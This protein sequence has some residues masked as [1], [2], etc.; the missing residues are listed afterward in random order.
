[1]SGTMHRLRFVALSAVGWAVACGG[2][3]RVPLA[4]GTEESGSIDSERAGEITTAASSDGPASA[5]PVVAISAQSVEVE[6]E[7]EAVTERQEVFGF[8]TGIRLLDS[9]NDIT[10]V[11]PVLAALAVS[12]ATELRRWQPKADFRVTGGKLALTT[13][14]RA[15]CADGRCLNTQA[16]LDLQSDE[17]GQALIRPDVQVNPVLL[18][19]ALSLAYV[20]QATCFTTLGVPF[21][22][23]SVPDHEFTLA[24][25]APGECDTNYWFSTTTEAGEP[26]A[27]ELM[28][29]LEKSLIWV[30]TETN[31]YIQF[32]TDGNLVGIDPTYGLNDAGSTQNGSCSPACTRISSEDLLGRCCSCRGNR[33][34]VRATWNANTYTCQ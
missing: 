32:Q 18:R 9:C 24:H 3:G 7:V 15:Q 33:N 14:G 11:D 20:R 25:T 27:P 23:C 12:T 29:Q 16:L 19:R 17:A 28:Q 31:D 4:E 22:G 1:M 34:Y 8:D 26:L 5:A 30:N 21:F 2:S 13:T 6:A 10:G